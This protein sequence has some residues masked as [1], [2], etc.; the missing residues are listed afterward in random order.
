MSGIID[1]RWPNV[2]NLIAS[3]L[4]FVNL[5]F[6]AYFSA[7]CAFK[8][9]FIMTTIG[10]TLAPIVVALCTLVYYYVKVAKISKSEERTQEQKLKKEQHLEGVRAQCVG[11][12]L[13]VTYFV[14]PSTSCT[15]FRIYSC[16]TEFDDGQ[17]WLKVDYSISCNHTSWR[18]MACEYGR[19]C[20]QSLPPL[21]PCRSERRFVC[22]SWP[23]PTDGYCLLMIMVRG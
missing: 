6:V 18:A 7:T 12:F 20:D 11:F 13:F 2:Y 23:P 14:F 8:I 9:N 5:N 22:R 19:F 3:K 10:Q 16:N 17:I 1:V 4:S 21:P 15:L